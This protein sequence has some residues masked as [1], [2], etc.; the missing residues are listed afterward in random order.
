MVERF[1]DRVVFI[2]GGT[3]GLGAETCELFLNEGARVFVTDLEVQ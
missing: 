1:H 2:T 3:S